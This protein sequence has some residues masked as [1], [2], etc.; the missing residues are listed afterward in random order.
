MFIVDCPG[1]QRASSL[2]MDILLYQE[3]VRY[4]ADSV[5]IERLG[6]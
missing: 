5:T 6:A 2:V 4:P 3:N 1:V